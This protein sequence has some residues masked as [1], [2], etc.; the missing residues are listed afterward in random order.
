MRLTGADLWSLPPGRTTVWQVPDGCGA[1]NVTPA[2]LTL[3]QAHHLSAAATGVPTVWLAVSLRIQRALSASEVAQAATRLIARHSALRTAISMDADGGFSAAVLDPAAVRLEASALD[4]AE[5]W[6]VVDEVCRPGRDAPAI[7]VVTVEQPGATEVLVAIDHVHT[8]ALSMVQVAAD[9]VADLDGHALAAAP[10]YVAEVQ[11]WLDAPAV[12]PADP[13]LTAWHD[14]L[15]VT[16]DEPPSFPFDLGVAP[17]TTAPQR[18]MVALLADAAT[19]DLVAA[20]AQR[21]VQSTFATVLTGLQRAVVELGG[22]TQ[23]PVLLPA[24]NREG[25]HA[26]GIGWYATTVPLVIPDDPQ[27][28]LLARS[29]ARSIALADVPLD[30]V[31]QSLPRPLRRPRQDVFMVS[32]LDYRRIDRWSSLQGT[33]PIQL[34]R[35]TQCDDVQIWVT[36]TD[37]G[38][39]VRCRL[40]GTPEAEAAVGAVIAAWRDELDRLAGVV[41]R[42]AAPGRVDPVPVRI[43]TNA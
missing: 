11:R 5:V 17:G 30:Q 6:P 3:N 26:T 19:A 31:L 35:A 22:P 25:E 10:C 20:S 38:L 2:P 42:A 39:A 27:G 43:P 37:E 40:P 28:G 24:R 7:A 29:I 21:R 12:D 8:D 4:P 13:R 32:Y 1:D 34:S 41:G 23:L 36:R 14:M 33:Q 16:A 9:L 15:E 18:T